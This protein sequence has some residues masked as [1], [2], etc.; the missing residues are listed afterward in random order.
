MP[1]SE[2][3]RKIMRVDARCEKEVEAVRRKYKM[4]AEKY[5]DKCTHKWDDG[6]DAT[7]TWRDGYNDYRTECQICGREV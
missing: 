5:R 4:L 2:L 1:R 7:H 6:S 3:L